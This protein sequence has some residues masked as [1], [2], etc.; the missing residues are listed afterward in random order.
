MDL[1]TGKILIEYSILQQL[2]IIER[3][4]FAAAIGGTIAV[5]GVI[6][7]SLHYSNKQ[8]YNSKEQIVKR[9]VHRVKT[10]FQMNKWDHDH[11]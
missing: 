11:A 3:K 9:F 7:V 1:F 5:A 8:K 4:V 6:G 2:W 10:A